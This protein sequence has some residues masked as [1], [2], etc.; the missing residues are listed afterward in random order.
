MAA[1][2]DSNNYVILI[3]IYKKKEILNV[4]VCCVNI[5]MQLSENPTILVYMPH[6]RIIHVNVFKELLS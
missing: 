3:Y 5:F 2:L 4:Y 1:H 6:L